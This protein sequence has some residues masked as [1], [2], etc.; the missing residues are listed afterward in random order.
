VILEL[1]EPRV[2]SGVWDHTT[3]RVRP[4]ERMQRTG[5]AAMLA[6]YGPHSRTEA[7][8]A[9]VNRLHDRI[10]GET[11]GGVAYRAR[12]AELLAW[13]HATANFG[14]LEAYRACVRPLSAAEADRYYAEWQGVA[15]LYGV[16][17]PCR[18]ESEVAALFASMAPSLERSEIVF[19]FLRIVRRMPALPWALRPLQALLVKAAVQCVP[20]WARERLGLDGPEWAPSPWQWRLLRNVGR[21]ADRLPLA[22]HPAVLACRRLGL[23]EDLVYRD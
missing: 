23:P 13:V 3:F 22:T 10:A 21:A 4:I 17:S 2:R 19:E 1:A 7:M 8:I 12:D 5:H 20:A 11:P 18:T 15:R 6:V 14:F 9:H 16:E